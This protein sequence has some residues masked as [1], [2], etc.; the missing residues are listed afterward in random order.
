MMVTL[1]TPLAALTSVGKVTASRFKT[2]GL[3]TVED[4][5]FYF[6]TRYDDFR[7]C[8]RIRDIQPGD[9]VT[10][11]GAITSLQNKVTR[12]KRQKITEGYIQDDTGALKLVWFNQPYLVTQL[13]QGEVI[14]VSGKVEYTGYG[15][16]MRSPEWE[17]G[18]SSIHT[19]RL[20][21]VYPL[22][23]GLTQKQVRFLVSRAL[24]AIG[25]VEEW[26]VFQNQK[27]KVKNQN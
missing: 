5:L 8:K 18:A 1:I 9:M 19:G 13:T 6:P 15:L 7:I 17:K 10:V 20:A 25:E 16:E 23:A 14:S 26:M 22:T 21:P 24:E 4:L 11:R 3:S 12:Y 2:L 27:S